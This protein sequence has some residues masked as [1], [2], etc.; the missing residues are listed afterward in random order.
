[1][2]FNRVYNGNNNDNDNNDKLKKGS[3]YLLNFCNY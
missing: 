3:M 2:L 1:M